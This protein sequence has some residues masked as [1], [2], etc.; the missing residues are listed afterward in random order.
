M[1][2]SSQVDGTSYTLESLSQDLGFKFKPTISSPTSG[3]H[4]INS[5]SAAHLKLE[6]VVSQ[7]TFAAFKTRQLYDSISF[8]LKLSRV[9]KIAVVLPDI[10]PRDGEFNAKV[11]LTRLIKLEIVDAKNI[12]IVSRNSKLKEFL[13]P[14]FKSSVYSGVD[15]LATY[16]FVIIT[17]LPIHQYLSLNQIKD[18]LFTDTIFISTNT[19]TLIKKGDSLFKGKLFFPYE[20]SFK[21]ASTEVNDFGTTWNP[22]LSNRKFALPDLDRM[23]KLFRVFARYKLDDDVTDS[24]LESIIPKSVI[25]AFEENKILGNDRLEYIE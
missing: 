11:V 15:T 14:D 6:S 13:G 17:A 7:I 21:G 3:Q 20:Y 19:S 22:S 25:E 16:P 4:F 5:R 23:R 18:M 1:I 9:F 24:I 12:L 2:K 8:S 10:L